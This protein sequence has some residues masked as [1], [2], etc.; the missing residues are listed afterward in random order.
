MTPELAVVL[1]VIVASAC[2]RKD[3]EQVALDGLSVG[4]VDRSGATL[5][6]VKVEIRDGAYV[7]AMTLTPSHCTF[8]GASERPGTYTIRAFR[9]IVRAK[10]S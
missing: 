10:H 6:D 3:C 4:V 9:E 7:E 8:S 1:G 5:C 2:Q